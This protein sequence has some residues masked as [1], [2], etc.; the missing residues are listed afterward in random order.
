MVG[1][2][3]HWCRGPS[4][5]L[6]S[7]S[8]PFSHRLSFCSSSVLPKWLVC[9]FIQSEILNTFLVNSFQKII[10]YRNFIKYRCFHVFNWVIYYNF[11]ELKHIFLVRNHVNPWIFF[12]VNPWFQLHFR[13]KFRCTYDLKKKR[14]NKRAKWEIKT[15]LRRSSR[16]PDLAFKKYETA[17]HSLSTL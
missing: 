10:E 1:R 9:P 2:W 11:T 13:H 8:Q 15:K 12:F 17:P 6:F 14:E 16:P 4:Y 7:T 3:L 5:S